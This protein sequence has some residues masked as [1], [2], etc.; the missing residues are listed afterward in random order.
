[1]FK[2]KVEACFVLSLC[3]GRGKSVVY[4]AAMKGATLGQGG[5]RMKNVLTREICS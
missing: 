1:M 4:F 5:S 2:E 3:I